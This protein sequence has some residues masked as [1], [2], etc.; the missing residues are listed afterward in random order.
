MSWVDESSGNLATMVQSLEQF[1]EKNHIEL[2]GERELSEPQKALSVEIFQN[3]RIATSA[4]DTFVRFL[5][6]G[7]LN[8]GPDKDK[9]ENWLKS[10]IVKRA[11]KFLEI[12]TLNDMSEKHQ[13]MLAKS[14][15][16]GG[17]ARPRIAF[18]YRY[19]HS[20]ETKIIRQDDR[21]SNN[22]KAAAAAKENARKTIAFTVQKFES[23]IV[24][25]YVSTRYI[26]HACIYSMYQRTYDL[27]LLNF[28]T[29]ETY[30]T[31]R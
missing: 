30:E 18:D 15:L 10:A 9:P 8:T 13:R 27:V 6:D 22:F 4:V 31:R 20:T 12:S 23:S 19:L 26:F 1:C 17:S 7:P 29:S 16:E 11:I 25:T 24:L 28:V 21:Y 3:Y 5:A 2:P 14:A